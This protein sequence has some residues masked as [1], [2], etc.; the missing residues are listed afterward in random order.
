MEKKEKRRKM[1]VKDTKP[2]VRE[3]NGT[4]R[5]LGKWKRIKKEQ[6]RRTKAKE[7]KTR[8]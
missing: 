1:K 6:I 2:K 7:T 4:K 3:G 5:K 8:K